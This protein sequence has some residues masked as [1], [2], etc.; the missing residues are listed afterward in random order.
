M[1]WK[2]GAMEVESVKDGWRDDWKCM[3]TQEKEATG[4]IMADNRLYLYGNVGCLSC[5][6]MYSVYMN[7]LYIHYIHIIE[8]AE[9]TISYE[10]NLCTSLES[11]FAFLIYPHLILRSL[12][13][14][15]SR[16]ESVKLRSQG[17]RNGDDRVGRLLCDQNSN[18]FCSLV[19]GWSLGFFCYS[20]AL[21]R[22]YSM[23]NSQGCCLFN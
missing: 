12:Q 16:N 5:L 20:I 4:L 17:M 19:N 3:E 13:K 8:R 21:F 6:R 2:C 15:N 9:C 14:P 22:Y 11:A 18:D 23:L 1:E 7:S 10:I